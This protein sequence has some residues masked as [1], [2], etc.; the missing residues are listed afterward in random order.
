MRTKQRKLG[1]AKIHKTFDIHNSAEEAKIKKKLFDL[2]FYARQ[3][4]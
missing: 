2:K 3:A 1:Q 4:F